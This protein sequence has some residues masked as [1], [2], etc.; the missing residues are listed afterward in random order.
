MP[1]RAGGL[2]R[3][4]EVLGATLLLAAAAHPVPATA[5]SR[6]PVRAISLEMPVTSANRSQGFAHNSP[7]V[8]ADPTEARF[9]VTA[10]RL[11]NPDFGCALH[12]S[13]DA[14]RSWAP[15]RIMEK[16]PEGADKCYGPEIAFDAKGTLYFLFVGLQGEGNS[17]MG[18]FLITS[19]D[20]GRS[21]SPPRRVLGPERYMVRLA[22]DRTSG[23]TGR[24]HLVWLETSGDPPTGGL[25]SP[26][27]P[28]LAAYSDDG[29]AT[30]SDPVQVSDP[31]HQRVVAPAV[32]LGA[33][34]A[35]HVLYYDLNDD[36]RDYQGLEGPAWEG[37]WSLVLSSSTD[38]GRRFGP[39]VVVDDALVP[40][41]RVMLIFTMPPPSLA[42][43]D[44]GHLYAAWH[45]ARNGDWD[46]FLRRS[47]DGGRTWGRVERMNDDQKGNGAHQYLPR[48]AVAP[49]GRLDVV[50]YDRRL[51]SYNLRNDVYFTTSLDR[52]RTFAPNVRVTTQSSTSMVGA[53]YPIPSARGLF[54]G[55]S[56]IGLFAQDDGAIAAW[57]EARHSDPNE[58]VQQVWS[59]RLLMESDSAGLPW[60]PVASAGAGCGALAAGVWRWRRRRATSSERRVGD[61][62][63]SSDEGG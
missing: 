16:L 22:I 58:G 4:A 39:G 29:G 43:D 10:T 32:A 2:G 12:L 27:N 3:L 7:V 23:D 61:Q 9:M 44:R 30:F 21:F 56:R 17:P 55:G 8:L 24:L 40:P 59:A 18:A 33:D 62:A 37:H 42:A 35:V 36:A 5:V 53:R 31:A 11:D 51:D 34:H 28:I 49:G 14:G 60:W 19:F 15:V 1:P 52:G 20:R 13:G 26:P 57:T 25:P 50:F 38:G 48:L 63:I 41:E 54:E 47:A 6:Q 46:V 45:D